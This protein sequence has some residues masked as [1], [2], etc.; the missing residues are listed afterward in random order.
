MSV[1]VSSFWHGGAL[2][3][4]VRL[5]LGSFIR[6]GHQVRLFC[7]TPIDVREGVSLAD[8]TEIFPAT[9]LSRF[10]GNIA[11]FSDLFRY[12]M[13]FVRGGWWVDTD[14]YCLTP[15]LPAAPRAWAGQGDGVINNA[16][17]KFPAGDPLCGRLAGLA[18]ERIPDLARWG[19]IGPDLVTEVLSDHAAADHAGT[20]PTFYPLH[21][22]EA[23]Y[24]WVPSYR[25]EVQ[26]RLEQATFLHCWMKALTDCGI[27]LLRA[28]PRDSWLAE[29]T[30]GET[31]PRRSL[32]WHEWRTRRAL[33]RY[34]GR[35]WVRIARERLMGERSREQAPVDGT[36]PN[37]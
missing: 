17:L 12:Q 30:R 4:L 10:S 19:A 37:G 21:W 26:A 23:H 29:A 9:D 1:T 36:G 16:I 11:T 18:R 6:Q 20:P 14:V 28:P 35:R 24:V 34:H 8:A 13:L 25:A 33:A 7:Y 22:L 2:P 15:R 31:W 5:C 3:P 32:P 27:D